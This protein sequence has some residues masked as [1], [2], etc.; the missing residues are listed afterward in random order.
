MVKTRQAAKVGRRVI[1]TEFASSLRACRR[2]E[3]GAGSFPLPRQ[4]ESILSLKE[5]HAT[6]IE[7]LFMK[8]STR[9]DS[10]LM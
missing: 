5:M 10:S 4:E 1:K 9:L 2:E 3:F 8:H 6:F 7:L